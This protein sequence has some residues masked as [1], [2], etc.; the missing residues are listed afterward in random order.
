MI[1]W[2]FSKNTINYLGI[3]KIRGIWAVFI[4]I[5]IDKSQQN[6][7]ARPYGKTYSNKKLS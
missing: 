5:I 2:L 3:F 4:K 1:R 7:Y 6:V